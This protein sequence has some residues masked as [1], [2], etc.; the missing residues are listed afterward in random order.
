MLVRK[1]GI[2]TRVATNNVTTKLS[3][4]YSFSD[5]MHAHGLELINFDIRTSWEEVDNEVA[6]ALEIP[7]GG[8]VLKLERL[9]GTDDG[10]TVFFESYFHPRVGLTGEEDYTRHLYEIMEKDHATVATVSREEIKAIL[11]DEVI[12][13]KLQIETGSPVLFRKRRVYDPGNRPIEYNLGYY[14]ADKFSYSIEI[15]RQ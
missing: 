10:P 12:G 11:A 8:K 15:N 5:E 4:W 1:K 2:G 13:D 3:N 14:Q 6:L 7:G 9:R